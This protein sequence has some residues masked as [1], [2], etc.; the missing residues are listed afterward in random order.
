M[1]N[2]NINVDKFFNGVQKKGIT[3][4][5]AMLISSTASLLGL[6]IFMIVY[7]EL[8]ISTA[9]KESQIA[10][11]AADSGIECAL[12]ADVMLNSF[13]TSTPATDINCNGTP[14]T[15]QSAS[16]GVGGV[17]FRFNFTVMPGR[18]CATVTAMKL[19][20]GKTVIDSF[21]ENVPDCTT[22]NA[23]VIQRGLEIMY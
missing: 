14:V 8:G 11:Y 16:D 1:L 13:S 3:L 6:G 18:S 22:S 2:G 7:G 10:F 23:R 17:T 9:A 21:G 12:Y 5:L 15:L 19:G 20:S 4:L